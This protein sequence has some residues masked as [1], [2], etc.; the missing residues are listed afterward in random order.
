MEKFEITPVGDS[1]DLKS[2]IDLI[3][4]FALWDEESGPEILD[5]RP[6]SSIL[7]LES[8]ANSIF[9]TFQHFWSK[10]DEHY[11]RIQTTLPVA[12]INRKAQVVLD[13]VFNRKVSGNFQP[14]IV[15]LLVPDYFSDEKLEIFDSAL[16]KIA[17]NYVNEEK[18]LI[19]ESYEEI[20][21]I[22]IRDQ[23]VE[24]SILEVSDFYSYTAAVED[25]RAGVQLFQTRNFDDAYSLLNKALMK[26]EKENHKNLI[27]EVLYLIASLFAQ[28]KKFTK[29][30]EYF[31]RLELLAEDLDHQKYRE[32]SVFMSGF[33]AYKNLRYIEAIQQFS[34]IEL[35]KKQFINEFQ[36]HTMYGRA[37]EKLQDYEE[38]IKK[39]KF[40]LRIIESK[41]KT[42]ALKNQQAQIT[43]ELGLVYY[44]LAISLTKNLGINK[45][46][47]FKKILDEAIEHFNH[48]GEIWKDIG[49]NKQMIKVS[50]LIGDIFEYLG[51]D[52]EFFEYYKKAYKSAEKSEDLASQIKLLKRI[53]QKQ[54]LLGLYEENV[55]SIRIILE[56]LKNYT[57]FDLHTVAILHKHLGIS[58]VKT[59]Q[60]EEGL[61]EL[62]T[63]YEILTNFKNPVDDELQVLNR[64]IIL[65]T[66][67][68]NNEKIDYYSEKRDEISAILKEQEIERTKKE[69]NL[70]VLKDLWIFSKTIGVELFSYSVETKVETDL[71]GGFMT[72]IQA[73]CHEIAYK[74]IDSMIFG[75][76]RFTIYQEED[77]DFYILARSSAKVS[78]ELSE[79]ILATIYNR[80][81]KEYYNEINNFEGNVTAFKRFTKVLESFDWTLISMEVEHERILPRAKLTEK[82]EEM[83]ELVQAEEL[84]ALAMSEELKARAMEK[85]EAL[86]KQSTFMDELKE[87]EIT[88]EGLKIFKEKKI[89]L[90]HKGPIEGYN[91]MCPDCGALYCVKCVEAL[92][93]IENFCWSCDAI[94]NPSKPSQKEDLKK[95]EYK[96]KIDDEIIEEEGEITH[97][98]SKTEVMH[99]AP[100]EETIHKA[101][102]EETMHKAPKVE[103]KERAPKKETLRIAVKKKKE[104]N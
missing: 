5:F 6:E 75:D 25:F 32:L 102:K 97:K 36:Y 41:Q 55:E 59:D 52:S 62:E 7:D 93:E 64:I 16:S 21:D 54:D 22:Y 42:A 1:K 14:F 103:T 56:K 48:S 74:N 58:L 92:I 68:G 39:L 11:D 71:L 95:E 101:P 76:E 47:Q 44:K 85:R 65:Y 30:E 18:V 29:A 2:Q 28:Q 20:D 19:K 88:E 33:C 70:A 96:L 17:K 60:T 49:D 91:F 8:L 61:S 51:D 43:Y 12:N 4:F 87:E 80:F 69:A 63:S 79:K 73:L 38:S 67:L 46:E 99:K 15:V 27:M 34:K 104:D 45:Q 90:V 3:L 10:P 35:F 82:K 83:K 81:W 40:A 86:M 26:F 98:A 31:L 13:V 78:E 9:A 57:L 77:R 89:C 66:K 94:L 53:I 50:S 72:A 84:K 37:L 100:K 24:E 23:E